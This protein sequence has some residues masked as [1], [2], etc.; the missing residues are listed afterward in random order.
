M[1]RGRGFA[2]RRHAGSETA[3]LKGISILGGPRI[4]AGLN[5]RARMEYPVLMNYSELGLHPDL[6]RAVAE[7]GYVTC[8]P[9][10]AETFPHSFIGEDIYAQSQ[11]G[12]GK[13]AAFL[14]SIFQRIMTVDAMRHRK[15]L[16][17]APTRELAAQIEIEA[18][19]LAKHLPI[20]MGCFYGGV[21]YGPQ[22]DLL[23]DNVQMIIGTPGRIIDL[24]KQGKMLLK[25]V[26]FLVVDE[27]DRMFDMGFIDDLRML[28]RYLPPPKERQTFLYSAT[29][30]FRVKNLTWE[31]M[32]NPKEILIE[33]E[34]V[35]VEQVEQELFH[36]GSNE[37]LRFLLGILAK[38]NPGSALIF[39]NQ[40]F[41]AEELARRLSING[42][43]CEYIMGDLPQAK[44]LQVIN[45]LKE[46]KIRILVATDVAARGLDVNG[47]DLVVNYDVPMDPESYVHRIGRTARAGA[48]GRA[49]TLACEK[50]VY[51]LPAIEKYIETKIPIGVV[52]DE[53][54]MEDKSAG[55][56]FG[57]SRDRGRP[58]TERGERRGG[59]HFAGG[60]PGAR[61]RPSGSPTSPSRGPADRAGSAHGDRGRGRDGV[62]SKQE[63][64]RMIQ[65]RTGEV[66]AD[67][68]RP[69]RGAE[70]N[71]YAISAEE[72]M[73]RYKDKYG[74][75]DSGRRGPGAETAGPSPDTRTR[76]PRDGQ[77]NRPGEARRSQSPLQGKPGQDGKP[78]SE[79]APGTA[80]RAPQVQAAKTP[81][82]APKAKK[83]GL[84][85]SLKKILRI[86]KGDE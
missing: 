66:R 35:T 56:R 86:D 32:D 8:M 27:A 64:N 73:K 61:S 79:G 82:P 59:Q 20:T 53:L 77:R 65:P 80:P 50:F 63:M 71:P 70:R 47:L 11:T 33:A 5:T 85:S 17:L 54:M 51:G 60:R 42:I 84:F 4:E 78:R 46:G 67:A 19:K 31:Y 18:E 44:R 49:V 40:K 10:Q 74:S 57:H 41:M 38:E 6:A 69:D 37:K 14:I 52:T 15:V 34:T 25:E 55:M 68:R 16:I 36:V 2:D 23:R 29:L 30:N 75:T 76:S 26:G 28:L 9:V 45:R 1:A 83:P 39:C 72:R 3:K 58:G 62:V 21:S 12:T 13:T 48:K 22:V 81:V 7:A 24:I 43:E